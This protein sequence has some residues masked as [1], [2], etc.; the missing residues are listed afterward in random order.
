MDTALL[1][2]AFSA[3]AVA[4]LNPC[5]FALL[6]AYLGLMLR[7]PAGSSTGPTAGPGAASG[8][9][10]AIG[11]TAVMTLGFM[12]VFATFGLVVSPL[13][14]S[15]QQYL[16][17]VT[18]ATGVLL[19]VV[20]VLGL[21]GRSLALPAALRRGGRI[22]GS[23]VST[24]G[25]GVTYALASLTCT[26]GPFL[27]VVVTSLRSD[28]V[29]TGLALFAVYAGGMGAVVGIAA[30]A[31]SLARRRVVGSLRGTARWLPRTANVLIVLV[32]L[33]VAYYGVWEIRV[34]DGA[35]PDDPI[36]DRALR[37]QSA[38]SGFV[39]GLVPGG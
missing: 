8:V 29:G 15:V 17:W 1:S 10:R 22:D 37:V 11:L 24:F 13:A 26:V 38:L 39:G 23:L 7:G 20:G 34:L 35:D 14:A 3:G 5:G 28:D 16:P 33:Y 31:V 30:V 6:P 19:A 27:A 12:V 4:A 36:I 2:L 9:V 21:L 18:L 25:Y 32:G